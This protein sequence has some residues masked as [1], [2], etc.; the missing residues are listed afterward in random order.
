MGVRIFVLSEALFGI[1][2]GIFS[3]VLNLHLLA[4]GVSETQIGRMNSVSTL[5]AGAVAVPG[6]WLAGKMG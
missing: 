6:G 1:A 4:A 2:V 5:L 3:L